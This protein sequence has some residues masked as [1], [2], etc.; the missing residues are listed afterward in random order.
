M[1][2]RL[3]G[4]LGPIDRASKIL[5]IGPSFNPIAPRSRGWDVTVVDHVTQDELIKKYRSHSNVNVSKIEKV[6][7]VWRDGSL[8]H[9]VPTDR[10]GTFD[11]LIASHVI[12]HLPDPI[13]FLDSA[14]RLLHPERGIVALVV[15]DKRWC[16]DCL[17]Q[18]STTGQMLAAHRMRRQRHD[19]TT[20]F[21]FLAY[22][23]FD[24]QR[25]AW[26]R[27]P[28]PELRL[29]D[30]LEHAYS[31][32]LSWTDDPEAAYV[33]CH[34]WHFT[35]ASFELLILELNALGLLDWHVSWLQ[36]QPQVEFF[37][38][39][40][41]G[42]YVF[43]A[44]EARDARRLD[45]LKR[46]LLEIREQTDWQLTNGTE[47]NVDLQAELAAARE[48]LTDAERRI[49]NLQASTSWRITAPLRGLVQLVRRR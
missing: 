44:P 19:M 30:T 47:R 46:V 42:G 28:L 24:R 11:V 37:A 20:R 49:T 5:E 13:G 12:E 43:A 4:V 8:H 17:K 14:S 9:T 41:R 2:D 32:F 40:S 36:P 38:R 26:G 22:V 29:A 7:I 23:A 3:N 21:D 31:E 35:P 1:E 6:D 18:V 33:D 16:F 39:L 34:A 27:E 15:P 48:A 25:I 45:L 10:H